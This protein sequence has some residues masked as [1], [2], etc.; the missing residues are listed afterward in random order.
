[1]VESRDLLI[2]AGAALVMVLTP[3]P[4]MVYLLSRAISQGRSAGVTSLFGVAAGILVHMLAS[5]LGLSAVF[6]VVPA[7]YDLLRIAGAL[8]LLWLAWSAVRPGARSPLEAQSLP[9]ESPPRL[10]L[11]GFLTNL[12][13]PKMA[14]F[15]LAI[16]PQFVHAE[17]GSILLQSVQLGMTQIAIS[18]S[19]NLLLI[20]FAADMS[21][22]LRS[23]PAYLS[24][25]R[26]LLG[27]VFA[28]LS[29]GLLLEDRKVAVPR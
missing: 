20:L 12:L 27:T 15:Y 18:F 19:V 6:V 1:M 8:Y 22:W 29:V 11:A 5:A 26:Y 4:N 9:P 2:F 28:G 7:A 10:F 17:R 13:N 14:V 25:Q 23:R 3:G 24:A 16:F 21:R